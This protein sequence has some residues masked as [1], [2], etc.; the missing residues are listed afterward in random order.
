[1]CVFFV[2]FRGSQQESHVGYRRER[3]L[4]MYTAAG[5]GRGLGEDC[6]GVFIASAPEQRR[7]SL[8][9]TSRPPLLRDV[10]F[11]WPVVPC[12]SAKL[13]VDKLPLAQKSRAW[14]EFRSARLYVEIRARISRRP[15]LY[16][17]VLFFWGQVRIFSPH[18]RNCGVK[19]ACWRPPFRGLL[20]RCALGRPAGAFGMY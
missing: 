18:A 19:G 3:G 1:M 11:Q 9:P 4:S 20:A 17:F 14:T 16:C 8:S 2:W 5:E 15:L 7:R 10:C 6:R 13:A 12:S